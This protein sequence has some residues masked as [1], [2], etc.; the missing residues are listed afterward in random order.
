MTDE[1]QEYKIVF[2]V[3]D[4]CSDKYWIPQFIGGLLLDICE[5]K[6]IDVVKMHVRFYLFRSYIRIN[7][8]KKEYTKL[9]KKLCKDT[10]HFKVVSHL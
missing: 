5:K 9:Y 10:E 1:R 8:T 7:A 3:A 2:K 6:D 4:Y